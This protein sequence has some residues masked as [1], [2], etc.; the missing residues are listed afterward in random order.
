MLVGTEPPDKA[1]E[2]DAQ[3][4][5]LIDE[6][7]QL[8]VRLDRDEVVER[9]GKSQDL[10]T[11]GARL[12]RT[13]PGQAHWNDPLKYQIVLD[14]VPPGRAVEVAWRWKAPDKEY[15]FF[16]TDDRSTHLKVEPEHFFW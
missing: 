9:L 5:K 13:P 10:R 3:I 14:Y 7:R 11:F 4:D 8:G 1:D 15:M 2:V 6:L 16:E 12:I